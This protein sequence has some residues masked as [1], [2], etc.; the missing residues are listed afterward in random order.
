MDFCSVIALV[1]IFLVLLTS[2]CAAMSRGNLIHAAL[3]LVLSFAGIACI[4]LWLGVEF[5]GFV[6]VLVYVGAISILVI[7]TILLTRR[8]FEGENVDLS[9]SELLGPILII[10]IFWVLFWASASLPTPSDNPPLPKTSVTQTIGTELGGKLDAQGNIEGGHYILP[11]LG[12]GVLLTAAL[13]GGATIAST[14]RKKEE[15]WS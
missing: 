10:P 1:V 4:Y 15:K 13:I 11:M 5:L 14:K 8:G 6:Q 3:L 12:V 7:F 2:A 9:A